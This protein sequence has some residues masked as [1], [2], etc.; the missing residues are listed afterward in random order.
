MAVND[1]VMTMRP[2][3]GGVAIPAGETVALQPGSYHIMFMGIAE[4]FTEGSRVPV[5][6]T[7]E[8]AGDVAV[9]LAVEKMG[10]KA[11][12]GDKMDHDSM[13]HGS[14]DKSKN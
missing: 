5:V 8:K 2:V 12:G 7:F 1:G 4:P 11:P 3:E 6:L 9:E 14:M 10:A 13:S